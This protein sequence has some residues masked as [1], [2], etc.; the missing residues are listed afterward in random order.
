MVI[1]N[2]ISVDVAH[3]LMTMRMAVW[4]GSFPAFMVMIMMEVMDVF[5]LVGFLRV[6][7]YQVRLV[8]LRPQPGSQGSKHQGA[9]TES[10]SCG[11][12]AEVRSKLTRDQIENQPTGM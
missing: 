1:I 12:H 6:D 5:V 9:H 10:Q 2:D 8:M 3:R 7:V 4:F 11:F